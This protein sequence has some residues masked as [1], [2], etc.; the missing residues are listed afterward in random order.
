MSLEEAL[1]F[2]HKTSNNKNFE[3]SI[4]LIGNDTPNRQNIAEFVIR[5]S[6]LL[7]DDTLLAKFRKFWYGGYFLLK[8]KTK[9]TQFTI[10]VEVIG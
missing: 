7:I 10:L 2:E 5:G 6:I 9:T 4:I 3:S 1:L 8:I